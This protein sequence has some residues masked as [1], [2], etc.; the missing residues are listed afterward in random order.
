M[1]LWG[2]IP[3]PMCPHFLPP[4]RGAVSNWKGSLWGKPYTADDMLIIGRVWL[5]SPQDKHRVKYV[6]PVTFSPV[7]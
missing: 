2:E 5:A 7:L 1:A 4:L 6:I 3:S